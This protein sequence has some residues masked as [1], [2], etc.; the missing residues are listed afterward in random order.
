MGGE[1]HVHARAA[2][3][4]DDRFAL[5]ELGEIEE[6]ADPGKRLDSTLGN[7]AQHVAGVAEPLR[8]RPPQL[9]VVVTPRLLGH[10]AIHVLDLGLELLSVNCGWHLSLP[11]LRRDVQMAW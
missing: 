8:K 5:A 6:V 11:S 9:E 1:E 10:V 3:Q 4:I 7:S 2:A